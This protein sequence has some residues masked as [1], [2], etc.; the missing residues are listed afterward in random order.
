MDIKG[1]ERRDLEDT[2]IEEGF[3]KFSAVQIYD[4]LYRKRIEDFSEMSNLSGKLREY[5][6]DNF[7]ITGLELAKR[8]KSVDGTE[9]FLFRLADGS[10]IESALI[11]EKKRNTLCISTQVGCKFKCVFCSSGKAGFKRNLSVSEIVNQFL[12]VS[13]LIRPMKITNI[14]FMGVG[15]PLDN[16]DNLI[17]AIDIFMDN[18]GLYM[19]KRK[20]CI[21]TCGIIPGIYKLID[22]NLG[23]SL[24]LS[25]HAAENQTRTRI[26]PVNSR[27]PLDELVRAIK[28][29][30]KRF[31]FPVMFE[32][33]LIK[34]LNSSREDATKL[35]KFLK[36]IDCKLNLIVYNRSDYFSWQPPASEDI[37][38]FCSILKNNGI[39]YTL[40]KPRGQDINAACGQLRAEF[41]RVR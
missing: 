38:A 39:F 19:G 27:Y 41:K 20:I 14:V 29:F 17:K 33:I 3:V 11:P 18:K 6:H 5:L 32:Y 28:A 30:I 8:E 4:W 26:M 37:A 7:F 13:G 10:F 15:E 36:N 34:S 23:V 16:L 24:S 22:L 9:K 21:S 40:R 31:K 2:L 1:I 25:L 12:E 35:S